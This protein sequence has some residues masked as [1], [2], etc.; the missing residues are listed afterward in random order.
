MSY[1]E[2]ERRAGS[3]W[4]PAESNV[5]VFQVG[6]TTGGA[7]A[8]K[9]I[10]IC[11]VGTFSAVEVPK[12]VFVKTLVHIGCKS[13]KFVCSSSDGNLTKFSQG[14]T[15]KGRFTLKQVTASKTK[16]LPE[17]NIKSELK[18]LEGAAKLGNVEKASEESGIS[19]FDGSEYSLRSTQARSEKGSRVE[20]Y[21]IPKRVPKQDA[22][23]MIGNVLVQ[24]EYL[25]EPEQI[26]CTAMPLDVRIYDRD[27][28]PLGR[29]ASV[30]VRAKLLFDVRSKQIAPSKVEIA[31]RR[32]AN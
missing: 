27:F 9:T 25:P 13:A 21:I 15:P 26:N 12:G 30:G 10:G 20:W 1:Y 28:K 24:A 3:T 19:E 4:N 18:T 31:V 16:L 6:R 22:D 7:E 11:L 17:I 2:I 29:L 8:S 32:V 5:F 23:F 14:A